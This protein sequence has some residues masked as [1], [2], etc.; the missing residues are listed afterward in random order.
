[1]KRTCLFLVAV[2]AFVA[3]FTAAAMSM[4]G[5][6]GFFRNA[7]DSNQAAQSGWVEVAS[8]AAEVTAEI[9]RPEDGDKNY[10][11]IL[12]S[13]DEATVQMLR[14]SFP[15]AH[16]NHYKDRD[17]LAE[18][19]RPFVGEFPAVVYQLPSGKVIEKLSGRNFPKSQRELTGFV[20]QCRPFRPRPQPEPTPDQPTPPVAPVQ[21]LVVP[22]TVPQQEEGPS[23]W[24]YVILSALGAAGGAG[25]QWYKE[26]KGE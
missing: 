5:P 16:F 2:M 24:L 13:A 14:S 3:I 10:L 18:R 8:P 20:E 12:G 25:A 7:P 19:Y 4:A 15:N 26:I 9:A 11:T 1:M 23:A 21:P 6:L 17:P 22:D